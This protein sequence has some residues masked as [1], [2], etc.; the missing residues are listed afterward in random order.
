MSFDVISFG[1]AIVDIFLQSDSFKLFSS[2][3]EKK[4]VFENYGEKI[5]INK[6]T[7]CSGGGGTNTAVSFA[8]QG[9]DAALVARF[10]NDAFGQIIVDELNKE[11]LNTSLLVQKSEQTDNSIIL[12]GPDGGRTILVCRGQTRLEKQNIN[13]DQLR[14]KWFYIS[15]LEGN[16][17]L[18][19]ELINFA[20]ENE[21]RVSW[22]PGSKELKSKTKVKK[23]AE[24]VEVFNLN[25]QEMQSLVGQNLDDTSFWQLVRNLGVPLTIVTDGRRGAYL[26]HDQGLHF[27]PTPKTDP[28]DETGAGDAF[29]SGFIAGLIK[30]RDEKSAFG[31]AMKNGSSVVQHIG[32]KEGLLR[33]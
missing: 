18:A 4:L 28:V 33:C 19:E 25:R 1:S 31:L 6:R 16:L 20:L 5:E 14:A 21:I 32:A 15:S 7:I 2:D 11:G 30:G 23:L 29:G 3:Q 12:I 13:W 26:L 9:L 10:G 8:R 17:D 27:L 24:K 22:N